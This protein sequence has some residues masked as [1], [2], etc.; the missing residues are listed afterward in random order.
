MSPHISNGQLLL[1]NTTNSLWYYVSVV[2]NPEGL[3][4]LSVGQVSVAVPADNDFAPFV[5]IRLTGVYY[6]I[7]LETIDGGVIHYSLALLATP[8]PAN[9]IFLLCAAILYELVLY[10][11]T[12]GVT[13]LTLVLASAHTTT[14]QCSPWRVIIGPVSS[15]VR[16]FSAASSVAPRTVSPAST[17][18][19]AEIT[20]PTS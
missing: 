8:Q 17:Y 2:I 3:L 5:V 9:R 11:H 6:K 13:Y 12:D 15:I 7:T 1:Q 14:D 16:T 10:L 20:I 4:T 18:C 19:A